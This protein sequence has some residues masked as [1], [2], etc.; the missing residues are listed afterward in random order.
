MADLWVLEKE[1]KL[2][3]PFWDCQQQS[4]V[5]IASTSNTRKCKAKAFLV[6]LGT[7]ENL[8]LLCWWI[9]KFFTSFTLELEWELQ[10]LMHSVC[11]WWRVYKYIF[12][13]TRRRIWSIPLF[14][15]QVL[16]GMHISYILLPQILGKC[17][18]KYHIY[19]IITLYKLAPP[20]AKPCWFWGG[21]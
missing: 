13:Q 10:I 3:N 16:C 9:E 8:N 6:W 5:K 17:L 4:R 12:P 19:L 7:Q 21:N 1:Y 14:L 18:N 11:F 20:P 15:V 2:Q